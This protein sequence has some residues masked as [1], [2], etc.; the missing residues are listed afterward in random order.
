M[1]NTQQALVKVESNYYRP[2]SA[3]G[4]TIACSITDFMLSINANRIL[5]QF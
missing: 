1:E 5:W 2:A 3:L 4:S